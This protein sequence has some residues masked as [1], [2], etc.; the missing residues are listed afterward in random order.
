MGLMLLRIARASLERVN[1]YLLLVPK[2]EICFSII[3]PM[4]VDGVKTLN[5]EC[6]NEDEANRW[7]NYLEILITYF[8]KTKTI[9]TAVLIKK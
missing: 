1:F 6:P 5:V 8:K 2:A 4:T 9:K 7:F 3:G